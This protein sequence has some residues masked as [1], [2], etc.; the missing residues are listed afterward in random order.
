MFYS[1]AECLRR[2]TYLI[3]LSKGSRK[4]NELALS[5]ER[6]FYPHALSQPNIS[7]IIR[8]YSASRFT[9]LFICECL[10]RFAVNRSSGGLFTR[11]ASEIQ[12]F[13]CCASLTNR[14]IHNLRSAQNENKNK[15][16]NVI[17]NLLS[18][19]CL[20]NQ[21]PGRRAKYSLLLLFISI[22]RK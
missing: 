1:W 14:N 4:F 15:R 2:H 6:A 20:T 19:R 18:I 10:N 9:L 7:V 12:H 16:R 22:T 11:R 5:Y 17:L 8:E 21:K 3:P 13:Q